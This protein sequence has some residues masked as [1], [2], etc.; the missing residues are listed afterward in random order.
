MV[1]H[2]QRHVIGETD[3]RVQRTLPQWDPQGRGWGRSQGWHVF[4]DLGDAPCRGV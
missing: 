4:Q 2:S 1:Q 3:R